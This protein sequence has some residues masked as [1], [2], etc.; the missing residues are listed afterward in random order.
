MAAISYD[1]FRA[2]ARLAWRNR[3]QRWQR[4]RGQAVFHAAALAALFALLAIPAWQSRAGWG[5]ALAS[6]LRQWPMA[7]L[8]CATVAMTWSQVATLSALRANAR[9]EWLSALPVPP[10]LHRRRR[11]DAMLRVAAWQAA[12]GLLVLLA[13]KARAPLFVAFVAAVAGAMLVAVPLSRVAT[14]RHRRRAQFG[15][16]VADRGAGRLWRWQRVACGVALRGRTVSLG[17]FAL[18]AAPMDSGLGVTAVLGVSGIALALLAG[19]WRRSLGVLPQAQAW[20]AAQPLPPPRLLRATCAVPAF[21]LAC[22]I[23]AIAGV[24][25]ALGATRLALL[26]AA[27]LIALGGLHYAATAAERAR[28]RRIALLFLVHAMLLLG[29][30]QSFPLAAL[31]LWMVQMA[32]LMRRARR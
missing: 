27:A 23:G 14:R 29:L 28:P 5:A 25:L 16:P 2:Q 13:A 30:V 9:R 31:P 7:L 12:L 21:V 6:L 18:L 15:S 11:R 8:L 22:A 4:E 10:A 17:A 24:V 1:P 19:A 3:V 20:L 26:F 32:M